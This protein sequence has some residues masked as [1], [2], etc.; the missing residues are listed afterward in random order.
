MNSE[1]LSA[2]NLVLTIDNAFLTPTYFRATLVL[3]RFTKLR[4]NFS[5]LLFPFGSEVYGAKTDTVGGSRSFFKED[6]TSNRLPEAAENIR[7]FSVA[8][9]NC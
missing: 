8:L 7:V 2:G 6:D 4:L 3:S 1:L 5:M 9:E